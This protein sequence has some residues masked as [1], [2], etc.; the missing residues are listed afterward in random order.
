MIRSLPVLF[1]GRVSG[2]GDTTSFKFTVVISSDGGSFQMPLVVASTVNGTWDTGDGNTQAVT[3]YNVGSSRTYT[4]AGTYNCT[5]SGVINGWQFANAGDKDKMTNISQF[6]IFELDQHSCFRGCT[7]LDITASDSPNFTITN[8]R[9]TLI[10]CNLANSPLSN[11]DVSTVD[12]MNSFFFNCGSIPD[13]QIANWQI[14]QVTN[15]FDFASGAQFS[16]ANYDALLIAWDA[17]G[18]MSYSGTVDFGTSTYTSGGAVETAR[19]SLIAKWGGITD[20][21]AA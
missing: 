13:V 4:T 17:Q 3:A 19:T 9:N 20:G 16:T 2:G 1:R 5:F 8:A 21:G 11:W 7:N 14:S 10:E 12:S 6:G 15:F 18:A